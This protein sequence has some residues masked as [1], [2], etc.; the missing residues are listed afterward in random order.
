MAALCWSHM[1]TTVE[2][3]KHWLHCATAVKDTTHGNLTKPPRLPLRRGHDLWSGPGQRDL[4]GGACRCSSQFPKSDIWARRRFQSKLLPLQPRAAFF[5]LSYTPPLR[6]AAILYMEICLF[7]AESAS[8]DFKVVQRRLR[9]PVKPVNIASQQ[10]VEG[11]DFYLW[12]SETQSGATFEACQS[13]GPWGKAYC[14]QIDPAPLV[15]FI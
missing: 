5:L 11:W 1:V 2:W 6:Q 12:L 14:P 8:A 4:A 9:P 10:L 3:G 7:A 13:T 15:L